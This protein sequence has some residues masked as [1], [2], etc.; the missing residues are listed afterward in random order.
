MTRFLFILTALLWVTE[1]QAAPNT[2]TPTITNAPAKEVL[3][4]ADAAI[5]ESKWYEI[6]EQY[7]G[8]KIMGISLWQYVISLLTIFL[9]FVIKRILVHYVE[10]W[11]ANF[12]ETTKATWDDLIFEAVSKPLN[13]FITI[14]SIHL[15][16]FL[17][18]F[19]LDRFPDDLIG[20]SYTVALG[21]VIIWGVYRMVDVVAHYLD[22]VAAAKDETI[23]GQFVPLIKQA[24]RVFVIIIG[25]LTVLAT[26]GINIA[27]VLGGLAV[28]GLAISMAAKDTFA[29]F[30]GT[31]NM[32]TDRPFKVGDWISVGD[33]IDGDVEAIGFRSTRIRTFG[34][35]EMTVPNG[36]LATEV[37]NNWSRMPRR[38]VKMTIGIT[39]DTKPTQMRKLLKRIEKI[40]KEDEG[41]DQG[42]K[43]VQFTGFGASSLDIFLYY[44]TKSTVWKEYLDVR[45]G[46]NLKIMEA[47]EDMG[48]E[49]AFPTQTLHVKGDGMETL[50]RS[51]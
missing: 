29:N 20:K 1:A 41:V 18:V 2:N 17:L 36:L 48:L 31:F 12:F 42:Y 32:L 40:L 26:V 8:Q 35:T 9:G 10:R 16:V 19:R 13:A 30:I 4:K 15:A 7:L 34:K 21:L 27:G 50:Q 49:F 43:L 47:V 23:R 37:I 51:A 5:E 24:L 44:F 25:G 22:D 33:K 11:L 6:A 38:R 28:G 39:Y 14:G 45:E 3:N 46:I